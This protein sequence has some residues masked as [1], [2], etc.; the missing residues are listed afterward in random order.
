L[1]RLPTEAEWEYAA[2]SGGRS[3]KYSGGNNIDSVAWYSSNSNSK[4]HPVGQKKANGLGLYDMTGN[5]WEWCSDWYD[6][7]YYRNSPKN[8][9]KGPNSGDNRVKRGGSWNNKPQ[10]LRAS[11]RNNNTPSNRNNNLGFRLLSTGGLWQNIRYF[12][13]TGAVFIPVQMPAP[14]RQ[15]VVPF[16]EG[17][18]N[19]PQPPYLQGHVY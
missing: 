4:T 16:N 6:S 5:V 2:R 3:E 13:D 17:L 10:N 11:N 15:G 12:T 1:F 9:P 18:S 14:A 19:N 7:S 8:N